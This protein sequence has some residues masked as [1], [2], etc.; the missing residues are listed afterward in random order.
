MKLVIILTLECPL[1]LCLNDA[2][3]EVDEGATKS[4]IKSAFVKS[5]K[6]KE[7]EQK[8]SYLGIYGIPI[9]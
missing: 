2:S 4:K 8:S 1:L 9:A 7:D 6:T 5:L 3:F